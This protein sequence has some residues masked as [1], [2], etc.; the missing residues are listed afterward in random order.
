MALLCI[1][2]VDCGRDAPQRF[3]GGRPREWGAPQALTPLG[4][5]SLSGLP[6]A[7]SHKD[8][9]RHLPASS[10]VVLTFPSWTLS[11]VFILRKG[12]STLYFG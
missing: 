1:R 9:P 8:P 4:F 2:L 10:R 6:S 3:T 5:L 7:S 11:G 12:L